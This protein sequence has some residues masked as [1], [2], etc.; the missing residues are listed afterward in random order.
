LAFTFYFDKRQKEVEEK[1]QLTEG[2]HKTNN[3]LKAGMPFFF[4]FW[5]CF[6][7]MISRNLSPLIVNKK[8]LQN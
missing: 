8:E 5:L 7:Q 1:L 3:T 6:S 2:E 4:P